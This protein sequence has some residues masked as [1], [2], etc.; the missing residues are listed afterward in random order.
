MEKQLRYFMV[1]QRKLIL[2]AEK[3][4][5]MLQLVGFAVG[6]LNGLRMSKVITKEEYEAEYA[7]LRDVAELR[8][9]VCA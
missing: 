9:A 1:K 4:E 2:E 5:E 7:K 8:E 3:E 6:F